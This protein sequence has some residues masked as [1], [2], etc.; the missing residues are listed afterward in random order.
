MSNLG[1]DYYIHKTI[2]PKS[3]FASR[4]II[5]QYQ[6][7]RLIGYNRESELTILSTVILVYLYP[8]PLFAINRA[9][10]FHFMLASSVPDS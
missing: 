8:I 1:D 6:S 2:V 4:P 9:L 7:K 5:D 3:H 10:A